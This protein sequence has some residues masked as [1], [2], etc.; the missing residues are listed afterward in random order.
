MPVTYPRNS[1]TRRRPLRRR[2]LACLAVAASAAGPSIVLP[3]A[4]AAAATRTYVVAPWGSDAAA[5]TASRPFRTVRKGMT[6]L[7]AGGTLVVR[8]GTYRERIKLSPSRGTATARVLVRNAPGE[9]PVVKGLLWLKNA[10]Y[11]TL[12][13]IDVTWSTANSTDEHMVKMSGGVG[14]RITRAHI[15]YAHAYAAVLVAGAARGW[16]IDHNW[17]HDTY[18]THARN[19]DHLIYVNAG[20]GGGVIE[21]NA[22]TRSLN[23]RGVKV[24]PSAP[25]ATPVGNVVIRYNTFYDNR[26]PSNIQLSYGASRNLIYRNV[27]VRSGAFQPSVTAYRLTGRGNV[28]R[29][30]VGWIASRVV[31]RSAGI[32]DAGGNFIANPVIGHAYSVRSSRV[33][34][35]GKYAR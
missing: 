1:Q 32:L 4:P 19:Q 23:G 22:L 6:V 2:L 12:S 29:D 28:V 16:R 21:R 20:M 15:G 24:G 5:G 25:G 3:A 14:W 35:Y 18:A 7:R 34:A 13:G 31:D 27:F 9:R 11:W 30:N 17:I 26:G 8:G 10:D 33:S